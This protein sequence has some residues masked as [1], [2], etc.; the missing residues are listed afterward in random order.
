MEKVSSRQN[1][2]TTAIITVITQCYC[3]TICNTHFS[4]KK[5]VMH[6]NIN[7]NTA[8]TVWLKQYLSQT[9]KMCARLRSSVI[10]QHADLQKRKK[11]KKKSCIMWSSSK[12][13]NNKGRRTKGLDVMWRE[14]SGQPAGVM[15]SDSSCSPLLNN[16]WSHA[17][18]AARYHPCVQPLGWSFKTL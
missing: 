12:Q 17:N 3:C 4:L 13:N 11:K 1:I 5:N 9:F 10:R 6:L 16:I 18:T 8:T 2:S 15:S 14:S 7:N